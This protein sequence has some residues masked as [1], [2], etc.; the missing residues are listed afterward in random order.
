M[1]QE[2]KMKFRGSGRCFCIMFLPMAFCWFDWCF[3]GGHLTVTGALRLVLQTFYHDLLPFEPP[4]DKTNKMTCA[5]SENSDQP[6]HSLSLD[7]SLRCALSGWLRTQG[8]F[9][10]TAKTLIRLGECPGWSESLLGAQVIWLVLSWGGSFLDVSVS[11]PLMFW[12]RVWDMDF[13]CISSWSLSFQ[14][15]SLTLRAL[16]G[17][18]AHPV[19]LSL[20]SLCLLRKRW[21]KTAEKKK[22]QESKVDKGRFSIL[23]YSCCTMAIRF[24]NDF[25][26]DQ[27][28]QLY[29]FRQSTSDIIF[30]KQ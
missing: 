19:P 4:H 6:G 18:P 28:W 15:T 2:K 30:T 12:C 25:R 26:N 17:S 1:A 14:F 16:A 13:D 11:F 5:P 8:F 20:I 24:W 10:Q 9:R 7:Q 21:T 23:N 27:I 22:Q 3:H 29:N